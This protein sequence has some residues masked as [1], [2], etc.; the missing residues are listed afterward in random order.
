MGI[1]GR[2]WRRIRGHGMMTATEMKRMVSAAYNAAASDSVMMDFSFAT[3]IGI[4]QGQLAELQKVRMRCR[5]ELRQ[6]GIAAGMTRIYANSVV[7]T[8]PRLSIN[9]KDRAW[10][11]AAEKAFSKWARTCD[12]MRGGSLG[13]QLHMCV[14]QFFPAGEYF[15]VQRA[16]K[17]GLIRLRY[18]AIRP[19]RVKLP[20]VS[21]GNAIIDN[22]VEVDADGIPVAYYIQKQDQDIGPIVPSSEFQR[23][24]VANVIHNFYWEDP[25]QHRGTPWL[26]TSLPVF[27]K[28]RRYDEATIAAAIVAAKFAAVLVNT[29]PGVVED[30]GEILPA[31]VM[32]I[33][34]G[35]MMVPPP[36]YEPKQVEPKHPGTNASDF[37]RD[38]ISSAGAAVAMPANIASQDSS[39]A[40]FAS[41]RFDGVTFSQDGVVL[42]Q[43]LEDFHLNRVWDAFLAEAVAVGAVG[44]APEEYTTTW[45]WDREDRHTDPSKQANSDQTRLQCG[46]ATV[47]QINMEN[48]IDRE[49]ARAALLEEVEWYRAN[50]LTHPVEAKAPAAP[51]A[52]VE[53]EED[54]D[55]E[56]APDAEDDTAEAAAVAHRL[57]IHPGDTI[58]VIE[59]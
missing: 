25:V 22:G 34:D 4:N 23:V 5:Y 19:D 31:T 20:N 37:R 3:N 14:R 52:P 44:E 43:M 42:R 48:G 51:A 54:A 33:Q 46:T 41:S 32:E 59:R 24:P 13:T 16:A 2:A 47:G 15:L 12:M 53:P 35:M 28:L 18:L 6:N 39:R 1:L 21:T 11:Q 27:H 7:G 45:L 57:E 10:S 30:A 56:D 8:G 36:G 38:Q 29:N 26:S 9:C 50:G 40:N 58:E 49:E 17:T 55:P